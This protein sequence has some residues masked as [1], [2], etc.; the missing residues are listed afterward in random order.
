[1]QS[2]GAKNWYY[3]EIQPNGASNH[4]GRV[5]IVLAR[6]SMMLDGSGKAVLNLESAEQFAALALRPNGDI[7][8]T[9]D[10]DEM[11]TV[12]LTK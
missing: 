3:I 7:S 2:L 11:D 12:K 10:P 9:S 6:G 1:M 4:L 5:M 8:Y